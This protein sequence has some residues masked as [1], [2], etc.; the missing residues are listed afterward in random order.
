VDVLLEEEQQV[1]I[2]G[3]RERA[4]RRAL[5]WPFAQPQLQMRASARVGDR[6]DEL[7]A[8]LH[9]RLVHDHEHPLAGLHASRLDQV[10]APARVRELSSHDPRPIHSSPPS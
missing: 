2:A 1:G 6:G 7:R 9:E 8:L 10:R 3:C 4:G 5:D